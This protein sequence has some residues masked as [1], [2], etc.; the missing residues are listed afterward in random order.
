MA[1]PEPSTWF[2]ACKLGSHPARQPASL[3]CSQATSYFDV[4]IAPS[5][6]MAHGPWTMVAGSWAGA[7][8]AWNDC[9]ELGGRTQV[10]GRGGVPQPGNVKR[11]LLSTLLGRGRGSLE[12]VSTVLGF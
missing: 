10:G 2:A 6:N 7:Q 5:Q 1:K 12:I 4:L 9:K 3:P 11:M 8:R